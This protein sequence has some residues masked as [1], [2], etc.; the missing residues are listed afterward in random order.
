MMFPMSLMSAGAHAPTAAAVAHVCPPCAG[1]LRLLLLHMRPP[2]HRLSR[3]AVT[4][5][6]CLTQAGTGPGGAR[7]GA[8]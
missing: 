7:T 8:Q 4:A 2:S 1:S 6:A 5:H 3:A